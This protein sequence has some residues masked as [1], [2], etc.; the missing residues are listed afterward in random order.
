MAGNGRQFARDVGRVFFKNLWI[1]AAEDFGF[2][3][4]TGELFEQLQVG[5]AKTDHDDFAK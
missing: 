5:K 1:D 3:D 4:M 2:A